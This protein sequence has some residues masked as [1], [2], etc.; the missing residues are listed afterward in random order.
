MLLT[1]W[2]QLRRQV[3]SRWMESA[4]LVAV[5]AEALAPGSAPR[6]AERPRHPRV[7]VVVTQAP[8]GRPAAALAE[9]K[10]L[11]QMKQLEQLRRLERMKEL[12]RLEKLRQLAELERL[13]SLRPLGGALDRS[14]LAAFELGARERTHPATVGVLEGVVVRPS[15]EGSVRGRECDEARRRRAP[16]A[17]APRVEPAAPAASNLRRHAAV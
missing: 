2:K 14:P 17:A 12:K 4:V 1:S 16:R 11:E 3:A 9:L 6:H 10:Q 8:A 5:A 7:A 13:E 15:T